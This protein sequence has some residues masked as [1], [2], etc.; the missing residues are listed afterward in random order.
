VS[1]TTRPLSLLS[2]FGFRR[3]TEPTELLITQL[4]YLAELD[5]THIT[6]HFNINKILTAFEQYRSISCLAVL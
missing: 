2:L 1:H 5:Y 6:V 3:D 4:M